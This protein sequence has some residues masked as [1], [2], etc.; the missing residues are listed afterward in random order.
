M[1]ANTLEIVLR[2]DGENYSIV[3]FWGNMDTFGLSEKRKEIMQM[4]DDF[5]KEYLVFNFSELNFLNSE[6]IGFLMQ[7]NEKLMSENRKLVIVEAKKNVFDVLEVIGLLETLP[8]Y[9]K[10]EDFLRSIQNDH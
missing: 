9:K 3:S 8:Y 10:M 7:I 5:K 6:S 4:V 2:E 1:L